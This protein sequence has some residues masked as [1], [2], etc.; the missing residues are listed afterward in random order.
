MNG[1]SCGYVKFVDD[2]WPGTLKKALL[3]LWSMLEQC[4]HEMKHTKELLRKA[5]EEKEKAVE[6]MM[7]NELHTADIICDYKEKRD[8]AKSKL[9]KIR[10]HSM[11]NDNVVFAVC[12]IV[13]LLGV[14]LG[15]WS[16]SEK[17]A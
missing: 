11:Q 17:Q 14:L 6:A 12:A 3:K 8:A 1:V 2:E 13:F 4:K 16:S 15:V 10:K 9:K 5:L 7:Q